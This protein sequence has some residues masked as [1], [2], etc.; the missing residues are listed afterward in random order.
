MNA[1]PTTDELLARARAG[2]PGAL[3]ALIEAHQAQVF[4]FGL[5]MCRNEADAEDVLQE[6][7][8]ALAR[9][10]H[11]LRGTASVSTW[12][13][14]VARSFCIKKR[15]RRK[16]APKETDSLEDAG[17]GEG[18]GQALEEPGAGPEGLAAEKE[19]Q[20]ALE[21]ALRRLEPSQREVLVLRDVEGLTAPE[22]AEIVGV[23][24]A[25]VKSRLHRARL[26]LRD[27]L[28]P[29]LDLPAAPTPTPASP[30]SGC[31]DVLRLFS[32]HLEDE[33][34]AELCARMERHL[35][36][37]PRCRGAC[38]S[39]KRSL[40]VCR[41]GGATPHAPVPAAVQARIRR[42]LRDLL[43]TSTPG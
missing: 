7:L 41:S 37:C 1:T 6:T 17:A 22:V 33:I 20:R 11:D 28:A 3:D 16:G 38:D 26:A 4:R 32:R 10:I 12:L 5:R 25:A 43:V 31:P 29:L 24:V 34:D 18:S 21:H 35:D 2:E 36:D 9:G 23:G 15:R 27:E 13:F 39:L 14:A 42:A 40:L 19:I 8:L 30:P